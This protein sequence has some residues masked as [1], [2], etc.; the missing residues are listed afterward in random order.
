MKNLLHK[1]GFTLLAFILLSQG[2]V[3]VSLA[4]SDNKQAEEEPEK[5]PHRG[6]LLKDG[7]FSVELTIFETGVPPEFR[8]WITG[9][10]L[11]V[12]PGDVSLNVTLTR[13][14]GIEDNIN[15]NPQGDFLRGDLV[16]YEPHSF[17]VTVNAQ[18][19]GKSHRLHL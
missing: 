15:F 17:V 9:K 2:N 19:R 8:V 5:G 7:D 1:I 13:L 10:G 12:T 4:N 3:A 14:G 11:P 6:R 18:Y 16:V